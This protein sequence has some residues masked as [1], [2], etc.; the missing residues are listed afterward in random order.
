[1]IIIGLFQWKLINQTEIFQISGKSSPKANHPTMKD[2]SPYGKLENIHSME[3][4]SI[5]KRTAINGKS[6]LTDHMMPSMPNK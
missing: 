5:H 4:N 6:L 2:L 1:M 3:F